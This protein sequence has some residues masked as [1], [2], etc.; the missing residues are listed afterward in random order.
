VSFP[1]SLIAE[2]LSYLSAVSYPQSSQPN[3]Q[4]SFPSSPLDL[5][6]KIEVL[7][8]IE[9]VWIE[10]VL[11]HVWVESENGW[12][13]IRMEVHRHWHLIKGLLLISCDLL[14]GRHVI[15][16][17]IAEIECELS[18]YLFCSGA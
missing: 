12:L 16:A 18:R 6:V 5:E 15:C 7:I 17:E 3:R 1:C 13:N 14:D 4:V 9:A 2:K 11:N 8:G 10:I